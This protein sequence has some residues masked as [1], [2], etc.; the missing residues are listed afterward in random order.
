MNHSTTFGPLARIVASLH[1]A[2]LDA[3]QWHR[4]MA[5]IDDACEMHGSNLMIVGG[6]ADAP[7]Y[8]FGRRYSHG[9]SLHELERQYAEEYF[10]SDER[11]SRL[12]RMPCGCLLRNADLFTEDERRASRTYNEFLQRADAVNQLS[13]RLAGLGGLHTIWTVTRT[14][15]QGEWRPSHIRLLKNLLLHVRNAV[16]VRQALARAEA[17]YASEAAPCAA[18]P[19]R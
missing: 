16:Q 18:W 1:D 12:F 14:S 8:R 4:A 7:E 9:V 15:R 17:R 10:S 5:L 13:A 2:A 3:A 11:V 19:W 6:D